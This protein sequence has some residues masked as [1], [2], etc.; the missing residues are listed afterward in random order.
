[1][2]I[3]TMSEFGRTVYGNESQGT[4]HGTSSVQF[5]IG[6]MV[7]GGHYG[8]AP[9]LALPNRWDRLAHT[10]DFRNVLGTT[11]DGW[12]GGGAS[13][14]LNGTYENLGFFHGLAGGTPPNSSLPPIIEGPSVETE[15]V[16]MT[17][18]R[19]FDT[20]NGTGGR[21]GPLG[22]GETWTCTLAGKLGIP[23]NAVAVAINLTAA[24]AT[25]STYITAW[26][27]GQSRPTTSNVNLAPG[28]AVPNL[29]IVRLGAQ[30]DV[31]F[32]N[33]S[34]TVHVLADVV[35]YFRAGTAIGLE[36]LLPYRLLDTRNGTGGFS[37]KIGEGQFIDLQVAGRGGV[38]AS[39]QA[40]ALNVTATAPT[41]ASYLTLWPTGEPRPN[42]SSVNM[43]AGQTI[44]NLVLARVGSNGKVSIFNATGSTDVIVDVLGCFSTTASGRYVAL[45]PR[46]VLDTRLGIGAP[47]ARVGGTPLTVDLLGSGGVPGTGVSGVML[48][49]TAVT[50]TADTYITVYPSGS[51][52]PNASNLNLLAGQIVANMV[53]ARL[54]S[55]GKVL[56]SNSAGAVDVIAD[57][58]GYFTD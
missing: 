53:L 58:V 34:G 3:A 40:V 2:T 49:V 5:V 25:Q 41:A 18:G 10:V 13:T 42:A 33:A 4:D 36:P 30:G 50:P 56:V 28:R 26:P 47:L 46:R 9:S 22:H 31:H 51:S 11:L 57:V 38:A 45:A 55:D 27:G 37:G 54:G 12:L 52:R 44:P 15:F 32:F 17:P 1:V 19:L 29:A 7:K 24:G 20:R 6:Q 39:P 43:V 35:G 48:N 8:S 21:T 23:T 14:I 16:S